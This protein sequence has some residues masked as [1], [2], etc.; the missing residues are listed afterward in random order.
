[1]GHARPTDFNHF[2]N[3]FS[4]IIR[5]CTGKLNTL[6]EFK[7][8]EQDFKVHFDMGFKNNRLLRKAFPFF[9]KKKKQQEKTAAEQE[10]LSAFQQSFFLVEG[11]LVN[12]HVKD[13]TTI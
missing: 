5:W 8:P 9:K 4:S 10:V 13:T 6:Q 2:E 11:S 1:L 7:F 3:G 12:S